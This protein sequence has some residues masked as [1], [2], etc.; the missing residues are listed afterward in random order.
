MPRLVVISLWSSHFHSWKASP[1]MDSHL[2]RLLLNQVHFVSG[3]F[4]S[5]P[6]QS[7]NDYLVQMYSRDIVGSTELPLLD[8]QA[9]NLVPALSFFAS[10]QPAPTSQEIVSALESTGYHQE[11]PSS[12]S[13]EQW[14]PQLYN[15]LRWPRQ[16]RSQAIG[17][18]LK[19]WLTLPGDPFHA[20]FNVIFY[21]KDF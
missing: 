7:S 20:P 16:S 12:S 2:C 18:Y 9:S 13:V 3:Q 1:E 17:L 4:V 5:Q 10:A 6:G 11:D 8:A 15:W 14:L 19:C 21:I